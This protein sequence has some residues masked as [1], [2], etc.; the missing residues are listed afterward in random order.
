MKAVNRFENYWRNLCPFYIVID[1]FALI[2]KTE[3]NA[4]RLQIHNV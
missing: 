4:W 3:L 1:V 2:L